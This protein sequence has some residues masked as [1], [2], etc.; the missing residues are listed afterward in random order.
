[1][2]L[3]IY[4]DGGARGNPG[5]A[6]IGVAIEGDG[7]PLAQ[8]GECMGV[9]TNNEA[10][11]LAFQ[12]SLEWVV[13]HAPTL[14]AEH[15]SWKLDSKLVVEQ[16][17][18]RWKIKEPRMLQAARAIWALQEQLH[19]PFSITHVPRAENAVADGLVNQALDAA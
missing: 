13:E 9:A 15:I 1:M 16:L 10:E 18:K 8:W 5:P 6:A 4:T 7:K 12:K 2:T 17:Q 19:V 14:Q 11:Y 3:T